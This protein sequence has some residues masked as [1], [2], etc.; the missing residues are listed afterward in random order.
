MDVTIAS[1]A[2][3]IVCFCLQIAHSTLR[4]LV[5]VKGISEQKAQKLK[6]TIKANQLV[7]IGFQTA[8]SR[9]EC[10][11]D[12]IMIS[13]GQ[14]KGH[15]DFSCILNLI[16]SQALTIW[17]S[18]WEEELKLVHSRKF[19]ENSAPERLRCATRSVSQRSVPSTK[20]VQKAE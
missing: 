20:V 3:V 16:W 6:D 4:K 10:M 12:I 1:F 2:H 7:P 14:L 18:F 11:K 8:T 5:E 17:M 19:S 13:T 9:L 15:Q